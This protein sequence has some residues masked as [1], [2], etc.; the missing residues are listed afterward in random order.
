MWAVDATDVTVSLGDERVLDGVDVAVESAKIGVVM[1]PNGAGKSVLLSVLAGSLPPDAG[2][3]ALDG[4]APRDARARL[5]FMLEDGLTDP[6]L[7]GR[8][9]V[10]FHADL[11]PR[12]TARWRDLASEFGIADDLD[13]RV[14]EYSSGMVRKLELAIAL[15]ADVPLYL[16]DEP[17]AELDL[18]A[19]DTFH[20]VLRQLRAEG[21]TVIATS[22]R[23]VDAHAADHV[24]FLAD[25]GVVA[26]GTP[27]N[28]LE[29]V[30]PVVRV[31]GGLG[32]A[33]DVV[34]GDGDGLLDLVRDGDL[35]EAGYERRGFLAADATQRD[36]EAVFSPGSIASATVEA[37]R[38]ADLFNYYAQYG[39]ASDPVGES[40]YEEDLELDDGRAPQPRTD[41]SAGGSGRDR[42]AVRDD[43]HEEDLDLDVD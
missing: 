24:T 8:E 13:R 39:S 29:A 35:F 40:R 1:G 10:A 43:D 9:N 20:A 26:R 28:L 17:T 32:G 25:D 30:P 7:T 6:A 38:V 5:R 33:L 36:V 14:A 18:A 4:D 15:S 3:V 37:P 27:S 22:H 23:P 41:E 21:R 11:H 34:D 31:E 2:D 16:L 42:D 12:F 19:V